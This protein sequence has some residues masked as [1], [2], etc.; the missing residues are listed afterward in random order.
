VILATN[1]AETS[2]TV[3]DIAAVVDTGLHKVARY[4]PER[5]VDSLETERISRDA[6]DQRAGRAGRLGPGLV[7]RL[8]SE[9]DR[10]R[11]HREP[12]VH[13]IDLAG[14]VLDVLAWGGDPRTFDWF[15]APNAESLDAAFGLL[16]RVGATTGG[17]LTDRGRQMQRL[18]ISPRLSA[19]LL[20]AEGAREAALACALLSE[21]HYQ[22][23]R[24]RGTTTSDL[25]SAVESEREL[26]LHVRKAADVLQNLVRSGKRPPMG[27]VAFRRALLAGYPDRVARRRAAG[28]DR[29]LLASGH[30]AVL[31]PESGVRHADHFLALDVSAGRRGEGSEALIRM[32]S[33][34]DREW[35]T[36][37]H[38]R[39]E[40]TFD[41]QSGTVRA[42]SREYYDALVLV[43][44]PCA[45]DPSEA[46][47]IL[48]GEFLRR[49]LADSDEQIARRL[50][51]ASLDVDLETGAFRSAQ[52]SRSLSEV[53]VEGGLTADERRRLDR[54]APATLSVP[55][56]R[57]VRVH[58]ESDGTV[59]A[60]VKL[61]ELFGLADTPR[62]GPRREP[63]IF[64]LLAPNG[65][66]VQITRD[67]RSFWERTYP[68]V[69]KELR[70][71]YPKHPW[72][73]D[74]WTARP[75]S[76]TVKRGV[77]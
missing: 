13:R 67:L 20:A 5:A 8:W 37:T 70:G 25:L 19:I 15:E 1:I 45:P 43:E 49:P 16:D 71:R 31:S 73:E 9:L 18:P 35:L 39:L 28:S 36:A 69:R 60:P 53:T 77:K 29:A 42:A 65:R 57:E 6:A 46:A 56:G 34:I 21:R 64:S 63:V 3:P 59:T 14:P 4:D 75:T 58:Y 33:A 38:S 17:K 68:E 61:Q 23:A 12:E 62:I 74:P 52:Q 51:F 55:S 47:R 27:E 11:P 44:R 10:L 76:R 72:P 50:R 26:P 22:P 41:E 30:G 2:L 32:A 40:H 48:T 24:H 66:P 54:L 7:L